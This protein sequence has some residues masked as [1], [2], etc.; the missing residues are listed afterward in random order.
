MNRLTNTS[1]AAA[2]VAAVAAFGAA[3]V[4]AGDI[5]AEWANVT[6]PPAPELK[7]VTV[8]PKTTALLVLD[9]G[10]NNCGVRPRCLANVPNVK[11]LIDEARTHDMMV[12][13]TLPG[14]N[15]A[16]LVD[17]SL[18]P[19]P[20]EFLI[21]GSGGADKFIRSNLDQG[22][23]DKGIKTVI[24]TGTSAQEEPQHGKLERTFAI[25]EECARHNRSG[26]LGHLQFGDAQQGRHRLRGEGCHERCQRRSSVASS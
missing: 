24:V 22:L 17:Q 25:Q 16:G 8:D 26:R 2:I 9:F 4:L 21:Q 13:Y 23:K 12:A 18:A 7:Q 10:K 20:G 11:K 5:T 1:C 15:A 14:Q 3:P 19:R 6:P